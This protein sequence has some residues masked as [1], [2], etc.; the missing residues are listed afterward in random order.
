MSS[1]RAEPPKMKH[2]PQPWWSNPRARQRL[3]PFAL[4]APAFLVVFALAAY[5]FVWLVYLSTQDLTFGQPV[6]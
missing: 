5:S 2:K 4:I 1:Q 6:H 3:I